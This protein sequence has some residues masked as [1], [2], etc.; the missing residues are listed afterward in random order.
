MSMFVGK[1]WINK[2]NVTKKNYIY[3]CCLILDGFDIRVG[4]CVFLVVKMVVVKVWENHN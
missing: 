4:V 1:S 3:C 2:H